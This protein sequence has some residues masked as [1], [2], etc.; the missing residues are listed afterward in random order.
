MPPVHYVF[1]RD[2]WID[3]GAH[4]FPVQKYL[5]LEQLLRAEL[6]IPMERFHLPESVTGEDLERV[7]TPR[8][9]RDLAEARE[10]WATLSSE[11]PV[12]A[13]VIGGFRRMVGGSI[14]A[15]RLA[16]QH[17]IGF[18]LG[19]GFHHAFPDHAEGFCYLHDVAIA[20]E[21]LRAD[22]GLGKVLFV[23]TD[24]H[25][26]NGSAVIY[27][28][29]PDTFTYSIHQENNYPIK[30]RSDLDR[31]LDDRVADEE[32]LRVLAADL[33]TI[34]AKFGRKPELLCYVA[35]V[36]PFKDDQLGGLALTEEGL[37]SR[38]RL[39]LERYAGRG[40]PVAVFLAGGYAPTPEQ[41]ARLH[42]GTA[43]GA[44]SSGR[45]PGD[46]SDAP[47]SGDPF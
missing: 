38:D 25:Q 40:V 28:Q 8:Y 7:H 36:D 42:L 3:I 27:A 4:V 37:G 45:D 20:V 24:V 6:R 33:E 15:V 31:G 43:R 34:D 44:E 30:Q 12:N 18:H 13:Q 2:N 29:D 5:I 41:T 11:L 10:T 32:Y 16:L 39:V 14:A 1:D 46:G 19:G 47:G 35:G 17:G 21:R 26:G 9:L 23:D 22:T